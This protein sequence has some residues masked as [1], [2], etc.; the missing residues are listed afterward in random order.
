MTL[1]HQVQG[2]GPAP[3]L[4][5]NG[6]MMTLAGWE[7][8]ATRLLETGRYRV[9]RCDFR[10]Q[11]ASPGAPPADLEGHV[12]EVV[13]LLDVLHLDAVHVVGT[14]F[15]GEV[16]LLLAATHPERVASLAG[17]TV[18]DHLNDE[19]A[20]GVDRSRHHV[21]E[22]RAGGDRGLFQRRVAEEVYSEEFRRTHEDFLAAVRE[23]SAHLP[24]RWFDDLDGIL[25]AYR[26]TDLR[27]VLP[28]IR[29]PV[30]VVIA[31]DDRV[32]PP[33]RS[34]ALASSLEGATEVVVVTH[35]TS[36][37]ALVVEQPEWLA[38]VCLSFL[39]RQTVDGETS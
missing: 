16:G 33:E 20:D 18:T 6:G 26:A 29:C 3:V 37:H 23:R 15:G 12:A 7:P 36:G 38:D 21:A 35:P 22:V 1:F 14:S 17:V 13:G 8:L 4:M 25:A 32:M 34:R 2:D 19:M 10:G 30:L 9:V 39:D 5:L 28:H 27:S 11:L 31:G 24:E